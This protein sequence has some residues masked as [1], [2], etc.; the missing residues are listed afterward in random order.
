MKEIE[1]WD[2]QPG[3]EYYFKHYSAKCKGIFNRYYESD[4]VDFVIMEK[5]VVFINRDHPNE[6]YGTPASEEDHSSHSYHADSCHFYAP[7]K[8]EILQKVTNRI[9]KEITGDPSFTFF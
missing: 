1:Y 9:L 3:K 2:L 5:V 7:K 8:E 4:K 6:H